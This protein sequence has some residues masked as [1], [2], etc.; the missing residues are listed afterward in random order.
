MGV[1]SAYLSKGEEEGEDALILD[2]HPIRCS[3]DGADVQQ[4]KRATR[5]RP[6]VMARLGEVEAAQA[7]HSSSTSTNCASSRDRGDPRDRSREGVG[8]AGARDR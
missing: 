5:V 4:P 1:S 6:H 2:R 3:H 8:A 7:A